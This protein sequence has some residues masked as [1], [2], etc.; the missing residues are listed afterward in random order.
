MV[1]FASIL[2]IPLLVCLAAF[3]LSKE[4]ICWKEV[5]IMALVQSVVAGISAAICYSSNTGDVEVLNGFVTGKQQTRVSCSHSYSCNCHQVC[6]GSGKNRSCSQHC[7][8]CYEHSND[9]DWDVMTSVGNLEIDRI[10]RRGSEEPPRWTAVRIGEG[11]AMPHSYDNYVKA[12]PGTLF[13]H[14]GL[15]EKYVDRLPT[16]PNDIY[17][18]YRLNRLVVVGGAVV[19]GQRWNEDLMELNAA[20]GARKQV[21][22]IVV[23]A[24]NQPHDYF[25][26]LQES[27][28]GGK[29][30]DVV[31]VVGTDYERKPR[32]AEVMTWTTND[33]FK[34]K[35]RDA[36]MDMP[37]VERQ[38]TINAL[39]STIVT[40]HQRKPMAD[41]HYLMSS[42]TPSATQWAVT[43]IIG[44][45]LSIGMSIYFHQN[46]TFPEYHYNR[47]PWS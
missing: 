2:I 35:L 11:V 9:W 37:M 21:N 32:W 36:V 29:K 43:L 18:Y 17:D 33:L 28:I 22:I 8:T 20:L 10:D 23:I 39:R 45:L 42:I 31:L 12:S 4:K 19:D 26:A 25:Y 46:E 30:N 16:Y 3:L 41:F 13:R 27:W 34:I 24:K 47:R 5:L 1:L 6:T 7:D 44:L 38:P 40:Y 15:K 14:Q